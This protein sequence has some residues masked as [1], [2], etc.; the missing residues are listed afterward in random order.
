MYYLNLLH[1][2]DEISVYSTDTNITG[3]YNK[4]RP[5]LVVSKSD[6][7]KCYIKSWLCLGVD[8]VYHYLTK[9]EALIILENNLK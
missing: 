9:S 7:G 6:Q 8:P 5:V 1:E 4:D 2:N 3:S